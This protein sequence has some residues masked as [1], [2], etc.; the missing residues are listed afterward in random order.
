MVGVGCP[1]QEEGA[2]KAACDGF[3][4]D[5]E[6]AVQEGADCAYVGGEVGDREPGWERDGGGVG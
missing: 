5:V 1:G 3:E 4:Q 6:G 2:E